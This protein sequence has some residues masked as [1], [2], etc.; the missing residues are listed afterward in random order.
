M[1]DPQRLLIQQD[2]ATALRAM[3]VAGG[4]TYT[5]QAGS[6]TLDPVSLETVPPGMLPACYVHADTGSE[7]QFQPADRIK[8]RYRYTIV[9]RA[10]AVGHDMDRK[11]K[12]F[13]RMSADLEKALTVDITRGGHAID[14]RLD[15]PDAPLMQ[16]GAGQVVIGVQTLTVVT[17]H[18]YGQP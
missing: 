7:R 9:W 14:T 3:T 4:Y 5:V 18:V 16:L 6:V 13:E 17:R 10:D 2:L 15:P 8:D 12:V 11:T 1:A